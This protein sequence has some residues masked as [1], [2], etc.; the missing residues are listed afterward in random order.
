MSKIIRLLGINHK[1]GQ[2]YI[3]RRN[4]VIHIVYPGTGVIITESS[5]MWWNICCTSNDDA[6][7]PKMDCLVLAWEPR[8]Q[9]KYDS[10]LS[11]NSFNPI[12]VNHYYS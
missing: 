4:A 6:L 3:S 7:S 9:Y 5:K 10:I 1:L 12:L 8:M 11:F 2:Y